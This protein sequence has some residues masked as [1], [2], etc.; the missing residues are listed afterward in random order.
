MGW[1]K[2]FQAPLL[3]AQDC[4]KLVVIRLRNFHGRFLEWELDA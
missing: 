4:Q 2:P 3:Q 1:L